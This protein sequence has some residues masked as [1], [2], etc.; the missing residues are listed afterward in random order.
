M[1]PPDR[2]VVH[3]LCGFRVPVSLPS[4]VFPVPCRFRVPGRFRVP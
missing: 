3:G 2:L 4:G 1:T